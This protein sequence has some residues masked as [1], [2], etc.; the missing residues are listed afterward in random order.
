[1]DE[2]EQNFNAII[3]TTKTVTEALNPNRVKLQKLHNIHGLLR[4]LNFVFEL[5][6]KLESAFA[7][8]QFKQ[9][10]RY[11][12]ATSALLEH[13]Y[14]IPV[15]RKIDEECKDITVK[16]GIKVREKMKSTSSSISEIRE[17][18]GLLLG[19][20]MQFPTEL[21][22]DYLRT[23]K[24]KM[25]AIVNESSKEIDLMAASPPDTP[26]L[27]QSSRTYLRAILTPFS[28]LI[29]AFDEY[30]L[31]DA[32]TAIT[33]LPKPLSENP[34]NPKLNIRAR[35]NNE[36]KAEA[37]K[38]LE[39]V[40][41]VLLGDVFGRLERFLDVP[42]DVWE[43]NSFMAV[44]VLDCLSDEA[45]KF[46]T[47]NHVVDMD[48]R[49]RKTV[50]RF[51]NGLIG[52]VFSRVR[53]DFIDEIQ[54]TADSSIVERKS[55]APRIAS[56]LTLS[57]TQKAFTMFEGFV[58][59]DYCYFSRSC[60]S[61][62]DLLRIMMEGLE[63]LWGGIK[64]DMTSYYEVKH[65]S[66][67]IAPPPPVLLIMSKCADFLSATQMEQTFLSF[68]E[69][70]L[71]NPSPSTT[72]SKPTQDTRKHLHIVTASGASVP[73]NVSAGTAVGRREQEKAGSE[74]QSR[75]REILGEWKE[76]AK[77]SLPLV[78]DV[79]EYI[80]SNDWLTDT[81]PKRPSEAIERLVE[82]FE[83]LESEVSTILDDEAV[84]VKEKE[85]TSN[86]LKRRLSAIPPSRS[87]S[88]QHSTSST[89]PTTTTTATLQRASSSFPAVLPRSSS[90]RSTTIGS[91]GG[92][93]GL[94]SSNMF[95]MKRGVSMMSDRNASAQSLGSSSVGQHTR[96]SSNVA[97]GTSMVPKSKFDA[98]LDN[99]G[100]LF[101]ERIDFFGPVAVS[102]CGVLNA[103]AR[104]LLKTYCEE[105]KR[106]SLLKSGLNQVQ[107]DAE[108]LRVFIVKPSFCLSE[109]ES[110][111][112]AL[113]EDIVSSA[114]RR[115]L[116]PIPLDDT[117][118]TRA[119]HWKSMDTDSVGGLS[120]SVS[121]GSAGKGGS[122][123]LTDEPSDSNDGGEAS[124]VIE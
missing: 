49:V 28:D 60:I 74:L 103:V 80:R 39:A 106:L 45:S 82:S 62:D 94:L 77:V 81:P 70:V 111:L 122:A 37:R 21:A 72:V 118:L 114:F 119:V 36:Q 79:K 18:V 100:R 51:F 5:P 41:D 105:I 8:G 50:L 40:A 76:C 32:K 69:T 7:S 25:F 56:K 120:S 14:H 116:D 123:R 86:D 20:N 57:L 4:K 6:S 83:S 71:G 89:P 44:K 46:Q 26:I 112:S 110:I 30:F 16:V 75:H 34:L 88:V 99:I 1:M 78:K 91:A 27:V 19:L 11:H 61:R 97:V 98:M 68:Y 90:F 73:S 9:A 47:L 58:K 17:S 124:F 64:G 93:S 104:I 108:Y 42:T 53:K 84:D 66:P 67:F 65:T 12:M 115:C 96:A 63:G 117:E 2:L 29:E 113:A 107:I 10:V 102:R 87:S 109:D 13:Y 33:S 101:N 22:R 35:F 52:R 54:S 43:L 15:F 48:E 59:P 3:N 55:L 23:I 121:P 95:T 92:Q 38:D 31:S 24:E 85:R